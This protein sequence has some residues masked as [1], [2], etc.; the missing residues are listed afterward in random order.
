MN[1]QKILTVSL[2]VALVV[3]ICFNAFLGTQNL[4]INNQSNAETK[5]EMNSILSQAQVA[6]D[7]EVQRIGDSLVYASQQLSTTGI[8]GDQARAIVSALAANSSFIIDAATQDLSSI[9]IIVEPSAYSYSEGRNVGKQVWLNPNPNGSITPAMTPVIPLVENLTGVAM[10]APIFNA[11]KEL[12]GTVSVIFDPQ[13]LLNATVTPILEGKSYE[14]ITMQTDGQTLYD[15]DP[16]KQPTNILTNPEFASQTQLIAL[17]Y[18]IANEYS[19]YGTYDS[20]TT[21]NQSKLHEVYWTTL[22]AYGAELR[23]AIIHNLNT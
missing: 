23:F 21:A 14:F 4:T 16:A 12:I 2:A 11:N 10:V 5:L 17:T 1:K 9:M 22:T 8:S 20:S 15:S 7:A 13:V 18:H 3:S 6:V 19:G